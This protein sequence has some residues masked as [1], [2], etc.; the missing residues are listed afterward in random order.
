[1]SITWCQS[2]YWKFHLKL[3][4]V[5]NIRWKYKL[6]DQNAKKYLSRLYFQN[7]NYLQYVWPLIRNG[8]RW[9]FA[10]GGWKRRGEMKKKTISSNSMKNSKCL[11]TDTLSIMLTQVN[12][13]S[14]N[15]AVNLKTCKRL[16]GHPD[17]VRCM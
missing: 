6:L 10:M 3:S 9:Y 12:F 2:N 11:F 7:Y 15:E 5:W 16:E 1:M 4:P 13:Q 17:Q 14:S 8:R